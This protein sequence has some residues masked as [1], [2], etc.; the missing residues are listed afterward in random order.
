MIDD[1]YVCGL[2]HKNTGAIKRFTI[3]TAP[4]LLMLHLKRFINY[5]IR[6]KLNTN[7]L[8]PIEINIE[9]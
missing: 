5:P 6:V 9:K 8:F 4:S 2:C 3:G 7:I 1:Q